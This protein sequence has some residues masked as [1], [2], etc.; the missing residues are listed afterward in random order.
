[1]NFIQ[2]LIEKRRSDLPRTNPYDELMKY[3]N[4]AGTIYASFTQ[5]QKVGIN[6]RSKYSTPNGIYTYQLDYLFKQTDY[7]GR[8]N[9]SLLPFAYDAPFIWLVSPKSQ[10]LRLQDYTEADL[11]RDIQKLKTRFKT[12]SDEHTINEYSRTSRHAYPASKMWNITRGLS[13]QNPNKWNNIL[14]NILGYSII[15]DD[16]YGVI[17]PAEPF[18]TV[19]LSI[20]SLKIIEK[21]NNKKD[22]RSAHLDHLYRK[23]NSIPLQELLDE[24]IKNRSVKT[25]EKLLQ[26]ISVKNIQIFSESYKVKKFRISLRK[27]FDFLMEKK[28]FELNVRIAAFLQ[29]VNYYKESLIKQIE[30]YP[31]ILDYPLAVPIV[32]QTNLRRV[33]E[34]NDE[35]VKNLLKIYNNKF[36]I[37]SYA[38]FENIGFI[39]KY[40]EDIDFMKELLK[41]YDSITTEKSQGVYERVLKDFLYFIEDHFEYDTDTVDEYLKQIDNKLLI[42]LFNRKWRVTRIMPRST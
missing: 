9:L 39:S 25:Y 10:V 19:F 38:T 4:D 28:E 40:F 41:P 15:R 24:F 7:E 42:E 29:N 32:T 27:V 30:K 33:F 34:D 2:F 12:D 36:V 23:Q 18:Q 8:K 20:N 26:D 11:Q 22:K 14:R 1:M 6:P 3:F 37:P 31:H 21:I 35:K 17:H 13:G 16:G 5:V